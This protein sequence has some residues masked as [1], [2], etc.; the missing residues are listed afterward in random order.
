MGENSHQLARAYKT[1]E[2][3]VIAIWDQLC[4]VEDGCSNCK[5]Y[6][7]NWWGREYRNEHWAGVLDEETESS[8]VVCGMA[9]LY[10]GRTFLDCLK[11]EKGWEVERYTELRIPET[12]SDS[13][14][15]GSS[16]ETSSESSSE[17]EDSDSSSEV[18]ERRRLN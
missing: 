17:T 9:H 13:E 1:E 12:P 2:A 7:R 14:A 8:F 6:L 3:D 18:S 11:E 16:S 4:D 5:P 15:S 10:T